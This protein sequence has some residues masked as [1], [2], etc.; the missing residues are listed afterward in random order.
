MTAAALLAE[1]SRLGLRLAIRPDGGLRCTGK[2]PPPAAFLDKLRA[3][4]ETVI[5]ELRASPPPGDVEAS[6]RAVARAAEA[7][8]A[9]DPELDHERR[10]IAAARAAE[11]AGA[12][13]A[14]L[15]PE[16]HRTA[17]AG[18]L[19]AARSMPFTTGTRAK[20]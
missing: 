2:T 14:P 8:A 20:P 3:S 12:Y 16:Q 6:L 15:S 1:A 11:A 7:L 18:L 4:R 17:L 19:G 10:E 5:A 9:P 13:G